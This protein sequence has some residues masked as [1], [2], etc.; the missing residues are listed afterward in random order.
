MVEIGESRRATLCTM[1]S[2]F[3]HSSATERWASPEL[4]IDIHTTFLLA[5]TGD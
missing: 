3:M 5:K 2:D 1:D 4:S